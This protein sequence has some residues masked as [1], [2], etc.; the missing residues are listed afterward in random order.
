[1]SQVLRDQQRTPSDLYEF[2]VDFTIKQWVCN[3]DIMGTIH[4]YIYIYICVCYINICYIYIYIYILYGIYI[5]ICYIYIFYMV[6]IYIYVIYI[7]YIYIYVIYICYIYCHIYIYTRQ[8]PGFCQEPQP[9]Q[10][11]HQH[12]HHHHHHHH[13]TL[14]E[15]LQNE[16][17]SLTGVEKLNSYWRSSMNV[18]D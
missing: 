17:R 16:D 4:V 15:D 6:Y 18:E 2:S 13:Q 9:R 7:C 5:Y 10:A 14:V 12:H 1:M 11:T 3:G 8:M